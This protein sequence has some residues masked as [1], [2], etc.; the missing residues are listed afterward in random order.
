[1]VG[2]G[3]SLE[4]SLNAAPGEPESQGYTYKPKYMQPSQIKRESGGKQF[5]ANG[6]PLV[7]RYPDGSVPKDSEKAYGVGQIQIATAKRTAE[8][9]GIPWSQGKL[10]NNDD[11]NLELSDLHMGDLL[12]KYKGDTQL[13]LGAYHSGEGRVDRS[14][15]QYGRAGFAQGLGPVGRKYIGMANGGGASGTYQAPTAGQV[16]DVTQVQA[17]AQE[18]ASLKAPY[19]GTANPFDPAVTAN[20]KSKQDVVA[21]RASLADTLLAQSSQSIHDIN[22]QSLQELDSTTAAKKA[23]YEHGQQT[24][25]ALIDT[26]KPLFEKRKQIQDRRSEIAGMNPFVAMVKGVIDPD[27]NSDSLESRD[28]IL[29]GDQQ[30]LDEEYKHQT[31]LHN[32]MIQYASL[33][34]AD[35]QRLY[36]AQVESLS[37]DQKLAVQLYESGVRGLTTALQPFQTDSAILAAKTTNTNNWVANASDGALNEALAQGQTG[38]T[39]SATIQDMQVPVATLREE[40][41]RRVQNSFHLASLKAG[42]MTQNKELV[43]KSEEEWL[44]HASLPEVQELIKNGGMMNGHQFDIAKA[45]AKAAQLREVASGQAGD[46][47]LAS[48]QGQWSQGVAGFA[49]GGQLINARLTSMFGMTPE[50]YNLATAKDNTRI[51]ALSNQIAE[52][53]RSGNESAAQ[54]LTDVAQGE[55]QKMGEA[56]QARIDGLVETWSGGNASMKT[57]GRAWAS[58][59][60]VE[61]GAAIQAMIHMSRV[62][63]PSGM[64]FQGTSAKVFNE[65]KRSVDLF[66]KQNI[67]TDR[68]KGTKSALDAELISQIQ[69]RLTEIYNT[70]MIGNNLLNAPRTAA[71]VRVNGRPHPFSLV[72]PQL[73]QQSINQGDED[74]YAIAGRELNMSGAAVKTMMNEGAQGQ[75][76]KNAVAGLP[77]D[78]QSY[79]NVQKLV[80]SSQTQGMFRYLDAHRTDAMRTAP[81]TMLID[82]MQRREWAE[83]SQMSGNIQNAKDFGGM[84]ASSA[85]SGGFLNAS[86]L[87][88]QMA[89]GAH[90]AYRSQQYK[91]VTDKGRALRTQP[92]ARAHYVFSTMPGLS[93]DD[94]NYLTNYI[95]Q[96]LPEAGSGAGD[97]LKS[98]GEPGDMTSEAWSNRQWQNIDSLMRNTKFDDP[99]AEALRRKILPQWGFLNESADKVATTPWRAGGM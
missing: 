47:V 63:P 30:L 98:A 69:G 55:L 68:L 11:Y 23:L 78:Y 45:G 2:F 16:E 1:M 77:K 72:S 7:G 22:Q 90:A 80:L 53:R 6:K 31:N 51:I 46:A 43:D 10:L 94:E 18:K 29:R 19:Q 36:G 60:Q 33:M 95:K 28:N 25:Q 71:S 50:S 97:A 5:D 65:I 83:S 70:D 91:T 4:D 38:G 87:Y 52:L 34:S 35:Q 9:H 58:G 8:K 73:M 54:Q 74:G 86:G 93:G 62:G 42:L 13:A 26:S 89:S 88:N 82:L 76:W 39:G 37:T 66:D 67:G 64:R 12:G 61:P 75:T 85:S 15:A 79:G 3:K 20:I 32:D 44:N 24:T 48:S 99:R 56:R 17:T 92:L 27:Y 21:S 49:D 96:K 81:S 14:V 84:V 41:Q 59:Q 40:Q 57:V